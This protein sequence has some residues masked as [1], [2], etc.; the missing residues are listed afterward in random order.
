MGLLKVLM[1]CS[2]LLIFVLSANQEE[3]GLTARV[4]G[5]C[6]ADLPGCEPSLQPILNALV[7]APIRQFCW[8][9]SA[10]LLFFFSLHYGDYTTKAYA[11]N[12]LQV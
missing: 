11:S 12:S 8:S 9:D 1:G 3:K 4:L 10:S 2:P 6:P 5:A 7:P